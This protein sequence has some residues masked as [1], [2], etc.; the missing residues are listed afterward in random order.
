MWFNLRLLEQCNLNC[1]LCYARDH[2]RGRPMPFSLV[3]SVLTEISAF[4]GRH[5]ELRLPVIYL[6]GGEPLLHPDFPRIVALCLE[7]VGRVN[8]LTNGLLV[9]EQLRVLASDP[10]RLRVQV[11][12]DGDEATNDRLRGAGVYRRVLRALSL[13]QC[14]QVPHWISYT[15]SQVNR[16][17]YPQIIQAACQTGSLFNNVSPYTG[18]PELMLSYLEWKEFKYLYEAETRRQGLDTAHAPHCCG[19]TYSCGESRGGFAVNPDGSLAGCARLNNLSGDY[20]DMDRL[21]R[22]ES[23]HIADTC[24]LAKWGGSARMEF[25]TGLE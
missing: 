7:T 22:S 12:L 23:R 10:E 21:L 16:H 13:L 3:Q 2:D 14:R 25:L 19:F 9:E 11:S 18:A 8:V 24:M 4:L 5:P 20:R 15:V 6:S 17:S 1:P